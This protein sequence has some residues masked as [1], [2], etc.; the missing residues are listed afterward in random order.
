[1]SLT[2]EDIPIELLYTIIGYL[3]RIK[4]IHSLVLTS[5]HLKVHCHQPLYMFDARST[6]RALFWASRIEDQA[7]AAKVLEDSLQAKANPNYQDLLR[8]TPLINAVINNSTSIVQRLLQ[9]KDVDV[10]YHRGYLE[11][12][13]LICAAWLGYAKVVEL[14][15]ERDD[16]DVNDKDGSGMTPLITAITHKHIPIVNLLLEHENIDPDLEDTK[17]ERKPLVWAVISKQNQVVERLLNENIVVNWPDYIGNTALE[18]AVGSKHMPIVKLLLS[19]IEE[20][21]DREYPLH[22]AVESERFYLP[23][24]LH[25]SHR[26][27]GVLGLPP[28]RSEKS[29]IITELLLDWGVDP[30]SIDHLARTPLYIAADG[31]TRGI[32]LLLDAG[33]DKNKRLYPQ[34][35]AHSQTLPLFRAIRHEAEQA[36]ELLL[37]GEDYFDPAWLS[38]AAQSGNEVIVRLLLKAGAAWNHRERPESVR[39]TPL[40]WAA[41]FGHEGVIKLLLETGFPDLVSVNQ[42]IQT[43]Q[44]YQRALTFAAGLGYRSI[45]QMLVRPDIWRH[46]N[47]AEEDVYSMVR[48]LR[49]ST[50]FKPQKN[51]EN[52]LETL[53]KLNFTKA[54]LLHND[55][56]E[57][58]LAVEKNPTIVRL[59]KYRILPYAY[60]LFGKD[61]GIGKERV[62]RP[63]LSFIVIENDN[64]F[65]LVKELESW[66][67]IGVLASNLRGEVVIGEVPVIVE[68]DCYGEGEEVSLGE[69]YPCAFEEYQMLRE[70]PWLIDVYAR[71][72]GVN[73]N[74]PAVVEQAA[75]NC[76]YFGR[77]VY[78]GRRLRVERTDPKDQQWD[79]TGL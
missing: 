62:T 67:D 64:P 41:W 23:G 9:I 31:Y 79:S 69:L 47:R 63:F 51:L 74:L 56:P 6:C 11:Q 8:D 1:M 10:N 71:E 15:L 78:E 27:C 65:K 75:K 42:D 40:E 2:L 52:I 49:F 18:H 20:L 50:T 34:E 19:E 7:L 21:G 58:E 55:W 5:R 48:K 53:G 77:F 45:H 30:D 73:I 32:E 26:N 61:A 43:V 36:V 38:H 70:T 14:L 29:D 39:W 33:A 3:D 72:W 24:G 28:F 44:S 54:I 68:K 22:L 13:P 16:I 35:L 12:T 60:G 37:K 17:H 57:D 25:I 59:T 76:K 66:S 4:D 46:S